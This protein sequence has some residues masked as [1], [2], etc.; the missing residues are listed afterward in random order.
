MKSQHQKDI[1]I[2]Q[3]MLAEYE[4][5]VHKARDHTNFET[6]LRTRVLKEV[7]S[8]IKDNKRNPRWINKVY[9]GGG[10]HN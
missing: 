5:Y 8:R 1:E 4:E 10:N 9:A 6:S 2:I 3:E 7:L